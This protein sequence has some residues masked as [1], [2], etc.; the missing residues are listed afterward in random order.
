VFALE[1]GRC[2]SSFCEIAAGAVI[3]LSING[4]A[5]PVANLAFIRFDILKI[6][7]EYGVIVLVKDSVHRTTLSLELK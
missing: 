7:I 5:N 6:K 3:L 4:I 1:K 2:L